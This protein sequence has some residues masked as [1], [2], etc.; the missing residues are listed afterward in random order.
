M[1]VQ[2]SPEAKIKKKTKKNKKKTK[3]NKKKSVV[4]IG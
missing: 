1:G 3:K 2:F 4:L